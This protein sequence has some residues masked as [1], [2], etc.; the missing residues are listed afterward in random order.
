MFPMFGLMRHGPRL[1]YCGLCKT[2][3]ASYG[4]K[5]RVLLNHDI[6]FL[7]EVL[8]EL[9]GD[10]PTDA[11]YRSFNCLALPRKKEDIPVVLHYAAAVTVALA[12]FRMADHRR[13][14]TTRG[15]KLAWSLATR[16]LSREY[17]LAEG[18]LRSWEFPIDEMA[19]ILETQ[20]GREANPRSVADVAEPTMLATAMVFSHGVQLTGRPDRFHDAW[21][22][23]HTFGE[24][25][26]LLDAL[27]DRESDAAAGHFNPLLA[28]PEIDAVSVRDHILS[29]VA[30]LE[31]EMSPV[32]GA[33]LRANVEERLGLRLRVLQTACREPLR[34]R[35]RR[36]LAFARSMR[37]RES[38]GIWKGAAITASVA[39]LAF[40]FP[41]H[42]RRAESWQECLGVSMNLMA[43]AA[44]FA[45]PPQIPREYPLAQ[46]DRPT[47][48]VGGCKDC[49]ADCCIEGAVEA[50]CNN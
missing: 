42:A 17:L 11:R 43:L 19:A 29:I 39:I 40:V 45:T 10:S 8:L 50:I 23:G 37:S 4:H 31:G 28:F 49:F 3:G 25:I 27:E 30:S 13:D 21:R 47:A 33:R 9:A 22:L 44:V 48:S 14:A 15:R 5:T 35:F 1:P 32:H 26:Y 16:A 34:D 46:P 12:W 18:Q 6:A 2:L 36:A 41:H 24:L 7:S 38:V 20:A